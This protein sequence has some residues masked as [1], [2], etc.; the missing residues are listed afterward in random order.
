MCSGRW[1]MCSA[2]VRLCKRRYKLVPIELV[3]GYIRPMSQYKRP[4][5]SFNLPIGL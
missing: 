4:V 2:I 3:A 1:P 5:V